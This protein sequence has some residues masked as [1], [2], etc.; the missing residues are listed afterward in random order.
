MERRTRTS[1]CG[2]ARTQPPVSATSHPHGA[3]RQV[4]WTHRTACRYTSRAESPGTRPHVPAPKP[5]ATWRLN[6]AVHALTSHHITRVVVATEPARHNSRAPQVIEGVLH[7]GSWPLRLNR[8]P[9]RAPLRLVWKVPPRLRTSK[10]ATRWSTRPKGDTHCSGPPRWWGSAPARLHKLTA[11]A[12]QKYNM[13]ADCGLVRKT[14]GPI[15]PQRSS[16]TARAR[17]QQGGARFAHL[18]RSAPAVLS[19]N[20]ALPKHA[21]GRS[22]ALEACCTMDGAASSRQAVVAG[23]TAYTCAPVAGFDQ[24]RAP[25]LNVSNASDTAGGEV[26]TRSGRSRACTRG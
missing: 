6:T 11:C 10:Q 8:R 3:R 20:R 13:A 16:T 26:S 2:G 14:A 7:Q 24:Y 22:H 12:R 15:Q 21:R 4:P 25:Y 5:P 1:T 23:A 18:G 17:R 19:P 9:S